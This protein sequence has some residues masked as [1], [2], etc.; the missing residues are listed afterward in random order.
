MSTENKR[1]KARYVLLRTALWVF[2]TY[3][4]IIA[5]N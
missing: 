2:L 3:L 4:F 5:I 1:P